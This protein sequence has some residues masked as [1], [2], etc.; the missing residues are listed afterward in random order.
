MVPSTVDG[1]VSVDVFRS[2]ECPLV[3]VKL[4]N[5]VLYV[6]T[7]ICH[8]THIGG[9]RKLLLLNILIKPIRHFVI[10]SQVS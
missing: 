5:Y 9:L 1:E 3:A 4:R 8:I 10:Y 2:D 7:S 6:R